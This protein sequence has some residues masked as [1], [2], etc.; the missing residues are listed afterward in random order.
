MVLVDQKDVSIFA[1]GLDHPE[2]VAWGPDGFLYAGGEAGQIYRISLSGEV[3]EITSTSGFILGV[4]L[5][6]FGNIYAC[7]MKRR[8]VLRIDRDANISTF[9]EGTRDRAMI[10]P[11]FAVFDASGNLY[12]SDSGDWHGDN[13]CLFVVTPTG[14]TRVASNHVRAFPNGMALSPDGEFLYVVLSNLP[15]VVRLP[16]SKDGNFGSPQPVIELPG[17][18]PDGLAFDRDDG[19]YIS[20][21]TPDVIYRLSSTGKLETVIED[22]ER[23]LIASPTNLCFAGADLSFMIVANLCGWHLIKFRGPVPGRALHYPTTA[24]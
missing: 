7:D 5:D 6:G 16:I 14:E 22:S 12:V 24:K 9:S 15:G 11:N 19:L 21:Y 20:C 2:C 8:A 17:R 23:T 10:Q 1:D 3:I 4:T 13:G 18:V